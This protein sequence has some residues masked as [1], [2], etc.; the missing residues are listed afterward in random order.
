MTTKDFEPILN[1]YSTFVI[2]EE[3]RN[4]KVADRLELI[5][6]D[7]QNETGRRLSVRIQFICHAKDVEGIKNSY[8]VCSVKRSGKQTRTN[9]GN[10]PLNIEEVIGYGEKI[11]KSADCSRRFYDYYS[12]TG[13]K[14][15]S[16][17]PLSDWKAALRNWKD[18]GTSGQNNKT[19]D[20]ENDR[21]SLLLPLLL[22][23][24]ALSAKK[25]H[26]VTFEDPFFGTVFASYGFERCEQPFNAFEVREIVKKYKTAKELN[27]S[28]YNLATICHYGSKTLLVPTLDQF[29]THLKN[30]K[31]KAPTR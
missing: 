29:E 14:M 5:E 8:C 10:H 21:L 26:D 3:N 11:G 12:M 30:R 19:Q 1:G 7:D 4:Y 17:I 15:K 27:A 24:T 16:G 25:Y 6:M 31:P 22:K 23:V 20:S 18:Y 13:W 2:T 9:S 28:C